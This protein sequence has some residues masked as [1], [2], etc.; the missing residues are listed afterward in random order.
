VLRRFADDMPARACDELDAMFDQ[1]RP[2]HTWILAR[3]HKLKAL[4][5]SN[6][7]TRRRAIV[8]ALR[9]NTT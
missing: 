1:R 8:R 3:D 4:V 7:A 9:V 2:P 5:P 6:T